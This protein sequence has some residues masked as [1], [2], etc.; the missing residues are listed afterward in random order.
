MQ[1]ADT[2]VRC[3]WPKLDLAGNDDF[4]NSIFVCILR[5]DIK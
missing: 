1:A 3:W 5:F 2:Q 4:I